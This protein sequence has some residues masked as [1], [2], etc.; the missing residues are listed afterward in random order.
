MN[1]SVC[2]SITCFYYPQ[3]EA[4]QYIGPLCVMQAPNI[5]YKIIIT[6]IKVYPKFKGIGSHDFKQK[7]FFL[8]VEIE[9]LSDYKT[10]KKKNRQKSDLY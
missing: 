1:I 7:I 2:N 5:L 9:T 6:K 10:V 3:A 8:S 4:F